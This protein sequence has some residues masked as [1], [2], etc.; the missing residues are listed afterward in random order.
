MWFTLNIFDFCHFKNKWGIHVSWGSFNNYVDRILPFFDPPPLRGQFLYPERGQKQTFFD[1]LPSSCPRSY[2]MAPMGKLANFRKCEVFWLRFCARKSWFFSK[3]N[4]WWYN[5]YSVLVATYFGQNMQ[6][7]VK[8]TGKNLI[9]LQI[10]DVHT[11]G[12]HCNHNMAM[13]FQAPY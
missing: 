4:A 13:E 8:Q 3:W 12:L 11:A 6:S 10:W 7:S 5:Y 2:W 1:P 9:K